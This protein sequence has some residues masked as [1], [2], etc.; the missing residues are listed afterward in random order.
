MVR[1]FVDRVFNGAGQPLVV[2]MLEDDQISESELREITQ[3]AGEEAMTARM[4]LSNIASFA[5]QITVLV[6]AGAALARV[7]RLDEPRAMLAY[8]RT[9][10]CGVP[11]ASPLSAVEYRDPCGAGRTAGGH[12]L[13]GWRRGRGVRSCRTVAAP[14]RAV[15]NRRCRVVR[16]WPPVSALERCG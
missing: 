11:G 6:A 4:L 13:H 12:P 15:A 16:V 3:D 1:E 8:W 2:H 7:F 14:A 9:L 5:L 10:L